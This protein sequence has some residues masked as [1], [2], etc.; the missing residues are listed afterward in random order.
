MAT[1]AAPGDDVCDAL[2]S[3]AD[4]LG[5]PAVAAPEAPPRPSPA[6]G[7]A[8]SASLGQPLAAL[9][10]E[11]AVVVDEGISFSFAFGKAMEG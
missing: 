6:R 8:E 5:A 4:H 9:M 2:A 1:L 11:V 7:K 3:I 10:P